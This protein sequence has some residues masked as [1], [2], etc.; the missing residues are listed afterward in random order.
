MYSFYRNIKQKCLISLLF[1]NLKINL[2]FCLYLKK[3]TNR[4]IEW[5][6]LN[7]GHHLEAGKF[8]IL[9]A[10]QQNR[11]LI[12]RYLVGISK[13][14]ETEGIKKEIKSIHI[15]YWRLCD[16]GL[17]VSNSVYPFYYIFL[18]NFPLKIGKWHLCLKNKKK[19]AA[20]LINNTHS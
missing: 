18:A 1:N 16:W 7:H 5:R 15:G 12:G 4:P 10:I 6:M 19:A 17:W 3:C 13:K 14:R 8:E 11:T 9:R 20:S 2:I